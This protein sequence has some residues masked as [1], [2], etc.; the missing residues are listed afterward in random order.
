MKSNYNLLSL[1]QKLQKGFTL[2]ELLVVISIIAFIAAAV[3]VAL[4]NSRTRARDTKRLA[5]FKQFKTALDL[6]YQKYGAFPCGDGGSGDPTTT[7]NSLDGTFLNG[8][9]A[10][11]DISN[12]PLTGLSTEGIIAS[13]AVRDPV[14]QQFVNT[15]FYEVLTDRQSYV[16]YTALEASS[17]ASKMQNDNGACTNLYE[18]SGGPIAVEPDFP[19]YFQNGC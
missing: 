5:D 13:G 6:Y 16:L 12:A 8:G 9:A 2:I 15:Y 7:D 4:N 1:K 17:N 10:S 14:N 11:C 18:I 19:H 3:L